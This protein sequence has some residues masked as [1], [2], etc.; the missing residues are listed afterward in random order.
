MCW[1]YCNPSPVTVQ[2]EKLGFI[3]GHTGQG[4]QPKQ[5][6]NFLIPRIVSSSSFSFPLMYNAVA[7]KKNREL[8]DKSATSE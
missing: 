2:L 6:R 1:K 5:Q 4:F 3:Q 7:E 8:E